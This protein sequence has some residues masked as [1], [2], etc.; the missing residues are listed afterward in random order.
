MV[1]LFFELQMFS[2]LSVSDSPVASRIIFRHI[3]ASFLS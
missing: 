3:D 2:K 1:F